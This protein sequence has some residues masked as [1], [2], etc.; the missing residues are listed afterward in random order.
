MRIFPELGPIDTTYAWIGGAVPPSP[1]APPCATLTAGESSWPTT[2]V[3]TV[4]RY[5]R[6]L[7]IA[8]PPSF[9][10]EGES[11][12]DA[13]AE[14]LGG[15]LVAGGNDKSRRAGP[16]GTRRHTDFAMWVGPEDGYP[17][18]GT[19]TAAR[20]VVVSECV[21]SRPRP[22]TR[23]V[24]FTLAEPTGSTYYLGAVWPIRTDRYLRFLSSSDR[25]E[26]IA[27]LRRI[28]ASITVESIEEK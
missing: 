25:A 23:I 13:N 4:S 27:V 16:L 26:D 20:Q 5:L 19:D 18:T 7:V 1:S 2:R 22:G 14:S 11:R 8:A 21:G 28:L 3:P 15:I 12:I 6:A 9:T 10:V 17:T 24:E